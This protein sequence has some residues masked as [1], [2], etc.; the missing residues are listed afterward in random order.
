MVGHRHAEGKTWVGFKID[1]LFQGDEAGASVHF[2]MVQ[3]NGGGG[4]DQRELNFGVVFVHI[5]IYVPSV[6]CDV[7]SVRRQS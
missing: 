1:R 3:C 2:E 7:I 4:G 5:I 6:V